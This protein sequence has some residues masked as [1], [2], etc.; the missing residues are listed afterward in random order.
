ML[1]AGPPR[2]F[3]WHSWE[4]H[5][6]GYGDEFRRDDKPAGVNFHEARLLGELKMVSDLLPHLATEGLATVVDWLAD[7]ALRQMC[8]RGDAWGHEFLRAYDSVVDRLAVRV[9]DSVA[10]DTWGDDR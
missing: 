9:A 3:K 6:V 2:A 4:G 7:P 1:G 5:R 10:G 8:A